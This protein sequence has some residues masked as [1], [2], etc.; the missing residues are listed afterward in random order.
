[1]QQLEET[2]VL[3]PNGQFLAIAGKDNTVIICNAR[4]QQPWATY[5]GHQAGLYRR[6]NAV[7]TA[8]AWSPDGQRIVSGSLD[9]SIHVW[10]A[11]IAIHQRTLIEALPGCAVTELAVSGTGELTAKRGEETHRW[12]LDS[13]S[14][15]DPGHGP[16]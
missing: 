14:W 4:T 7:I 12:Q 10:Y 6:L 1:M 11:P 9:G 8:L 15:T 13:G 16:T 2:T 3:S 5:Y